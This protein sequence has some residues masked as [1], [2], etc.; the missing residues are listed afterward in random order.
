MSFSFLCFLVPKPS[1][2][3]S[4]RHRGFVWKVTLHLLPRHALAS[5]PLSG[6]R[7]RHSRSFCR[8]EGKYGLKY[9]AK[10]RHI[11]PLRH[12][13][14]R[15]LTSYLQSASGKLIFDAQEE[16][17]SWKRDLLT[18]EIQGSHWAPG[19]EGRT[20]TGGHQRHCLKE[21]SI[22]FISWLQETQNP[23][24]LRKH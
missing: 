6:I 18:S 19:Q 15:W 4:P 17:A 8:L 14:Q 22:W 23:I 3:T 9:A 11:H 20:K 13:L 10:L 1:L 12:K 5:P 24:S 2:M 7:G 21:K 16:I